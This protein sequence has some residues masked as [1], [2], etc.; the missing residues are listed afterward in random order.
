MVF[1]GICTYSNDEY[2]E[3]EYGRKEDC[4]EILSFVFFNSDIKSVCEISEF[5]LPFDYLEEQIIKDGEDSIADV[6]DSEENIHISRMLSCI[7]HHILQNDV[8]VL[9]SFYTLKSLLCALPND[10]MINRQKDELI[11]MINNRLTLE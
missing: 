7:K 2:C 5:S 8:E 4:L 10:E 1:E 3:H 9:P 6:F 11:N